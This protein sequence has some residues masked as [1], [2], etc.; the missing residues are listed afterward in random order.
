MANREGC[1]IL[2][3]VNILNI[4]GS[5]GVVQMGCLTNG[6]IT[7]TALERIVTHLHE[8]QGHAFCD[9]CLSELLSINPRQAVQQKTFKLG[10]DG[11]GF[12]NLSALS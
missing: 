1:V 4:D 6:G 5:F 7:M 8:N 10:K 9:D 11:F 12:N 2:S 3:P